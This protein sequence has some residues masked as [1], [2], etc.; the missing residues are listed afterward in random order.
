MTNEVR[1]ASPTSPRPLVST[2]REDELFLQSAQGVG[3]MLTHGKHSSNHN[4]NKSDTLMQFDPLMT[5]DNHKTAKVWTGADD[6]PHPLL[7]S[8]NNNLPPRSKQ[9]RR[10][11]H[12]THVS[13]GTAELAGIFRESPNNLSPK[14][15]KPEPVREEEERVDRPAAGLPPKNRHRRASSLASVSEMMRRASL[16]R[17]SNTPETSPV[18]HHAGI[19]SS[20]FRKTSPPTSVPSSPQPDKLL[21][22]QMPLLAKPSPTSFL[23]DKDNLALRTSELDPAAH[24]VEIP[25]P[26]QLWS[27]AKICQ[28]LS[29]HGEDLPL[30]LGA[31]SLALREFSTQNKTTLE[32][33]AF[34]DK[35]KPMVQQLLDCGATVAGFYS[36]PYAQVATMEVKSQIVVAF[37]GD[38]VRRVMTTLL[39]P[40]QPVSV[41]AG[42]KDMYFGLEPEFSNLVDRLTDENP[43]ADVV[44][45]GHAW[46]G[47]LATL[48]A[49]RYACNRPTIR[50]SALVFGSPKVGM[51]DFKQLVNSVAN[52]KLVRVE[53]KEDGLVATPT[54]GAH[55]GHCIVCN[56]KSIVMYK[57]DRHK[58]SAVHLFRKGK[59]VKSYC[60][61][62]EH[63]VKEKVWAKD[64]YGEDIGEGVKGGGDEKRLMV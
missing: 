10:P 15:P 9:K 22:L 20:A 57:F 11:Q 53:L 1:Q 13:L 26:D 47:A 54:D 48:A 39:H 58:P 3:E 19:L 21:G 55:A 35:D 18:V 60:Q 46:G 7:D 6:K 41:L 45:T 17:T 34:S 24:Q 56:T 62:L 28:L 2:P 59:D 27:T 8:A 50:V 61:A 36:S 63:C 30:A 51:A 16:G 29:H 25:S 32:T 31:S 64:F 40:D 4:R 5:G 52:L 49:V 37:H 12:K 38:H 42:V 23:Q 43:F 33:A 14:P 44:F